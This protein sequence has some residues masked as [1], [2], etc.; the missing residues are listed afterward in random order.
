MKTVLISRIECATMEAVKQ[1]H[2]DLPAHSGNPAGPGRLPSLPPSTGHQRKPT[3]HRTPMKI[4]NERKDSH[5][6]ASKAKPRAAPVSSSVLITLPASGRSCFS[7]LSDHAS[8]PS[9]IILPVLVAHAFRS[10]SRRRRASSFV[11]LSA[12]YW[13][14]VA[15]AASSQAK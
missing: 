1:T 13:A 8:R 10:G 14:R 2:P 6:K 3:N 11:S 5:V 9:L 12:R 4:Y 15:S 7:F